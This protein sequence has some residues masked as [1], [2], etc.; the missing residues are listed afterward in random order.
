M[1]SHSSEPS[2][3]KLGHVAASCYLWS[4]GHR[5]IKTEWDGDLCRWHFENTP[6]LRQDMA[7]FFGDE[8]VVNPRDFFRQVTVFKRHMY[9]DSPRRREEVN[10]S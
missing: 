1:D 10:K 9:Q 3:R 4:R 6:E 8:A 7:L 2:I 5:I